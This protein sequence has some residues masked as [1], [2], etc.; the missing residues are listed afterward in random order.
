MIVI[1]NAG[2]HCHP[3]THVFGMKKMRVNISSTKRD[4]GNFVG[5][6]AMDLSKAFDRMSHGLL[7]AKLHVCGLSINACQLIISYLK[8]RR[9]RVEVMG[10]CS[11]WTTVNRGVPHGSAK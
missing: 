8:D 9:Q 2:I 10:E 4:G 5:T 6:V 11:D 7:I 3:A 1:K